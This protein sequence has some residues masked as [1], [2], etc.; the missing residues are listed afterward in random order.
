MY[1][2]HT[3]YQILSFNA[4]HTNT[5]ILGKHTVEMKIRGVWYTKLTETLGG[6]FKFYTNPAETSTLALNLMH[7][8]ASR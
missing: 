4:V 6:N 7:E 8:N 2:L 5:I 1:E 3:I